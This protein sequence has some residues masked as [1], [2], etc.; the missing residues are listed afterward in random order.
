MKDIVNFLFEINNL[1]RFE[2]CGTKFA[3]VKNPDSIAEH[4]FRTSQIAYILAHLEGLSPMETLQVLEVSLFH[5]NGEVRVNDTH[6]IA[7]RYINTDEAEENAF[8]DQLQLLPESIRE[9]LTGI[10]IKYNNL[11]KSIVYQI[12]KDADL[13]ETMFQAKEYL[14]IGYKTQRWI[15]NAEK[16]IQTKSAKKIFEEMKTTSFVDWWQNLNVA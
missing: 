11:D 14:E 3:G 8:N 10:V 5:D 12:V 1:K 4:V 2:H 7:S 13:L 16:F 9:R 15:D 6:K